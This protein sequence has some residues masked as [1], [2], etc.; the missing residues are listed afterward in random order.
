MA[1]GTAVVCIICSNSFVRREAS[2]ETLSVSVK[3]VMWRFHNALE[4]HFGHKVQPNLDSDKHAGT[5]LHSVLRS[6]DPTNEDISCGLGPCPQCSRILEGICEFYH[7]MKCLE[8]KFLWRLDTLK[9]VMKAGSRIPARIKV[10]KEV[11]EKLDTERE[12]ITDTCVKRRDLFRTVRSYRRG[13]LFACK[14][15]DTKDLEIIEIN[16][17]GL[18]STRMYICCQAWPT[19]PFSFMFQTLDER[20]IRKSFSRGGLPVIRKES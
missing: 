12:V 4:R 10:L 9:N 8:L 3:P 20:R 5:F 14:K 1:A 16:L 19:K 7:E 13:L 2:S 18:L 15:I 11:C 6:D 17:L